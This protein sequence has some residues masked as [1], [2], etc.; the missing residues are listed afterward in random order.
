MSVVVA[1]AVNAEGRREIVGMDVGTS[2]DGAFWR[3]VADRGLSGV[4]LVTSDA[5]RGLREAIATVF[6]EASWQRCR[7]HFMTNLLTRVPRRA[8]PWVA[9][10]VRT[11]YQQPSPEEVCTPKST[12]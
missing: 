3:S 5:H 11:V 6:A 10:M 1:T 2:E 7:T 9:T 8:Q 12:G 4:E